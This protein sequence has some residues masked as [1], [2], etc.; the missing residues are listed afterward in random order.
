MQ[1]GARSAK[2]RGPA[3]ELCRE[4]AQRAP[5]E[6]GGDPTRFSEHEEARG[7]VEYADRERSAE[8]VEAAGGGV[9]YRERHRAE[10]TD[11]AR[12]LDEAPREIERFR[13]ALQCDQLEPLRNPSRP[14]DEPAAA[15]GAL[16]PDRGPR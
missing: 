10:D 8:R 3:L 13:C 15:P 11:L 4:R 5:F 2:Q 9:R 14:F 16:A 6:I 7:H 12:L 1:L